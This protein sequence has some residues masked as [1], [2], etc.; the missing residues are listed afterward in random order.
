M[1][2]AIKE[3]VSKNK[4]RYK[5]DGFDLD[6][7]YINSNIIAMGYPAEKLEGIYRNHID[8][9]IKFL[10]SKHSGNYW[11][12]NLCSERSYDCGKF[13]DRVATYAFDDHNPPRMELIKPFCQDVDSWLSK[14]PR[15]VAAVHCKA[16]KGRTGVMICCYLLHRGMFLSAAQAL[17][18]YGQ[19]RTTDNRGVTIPSQRRY[20]EYYGRLVRE[21]SL[22]YKPR[23]VYLAAVILTPVPN[24]NTQN[25]CCSRLHSCHIGG[26]NNKI[27]RKGASFL[28]GEQISATNFVNPIF[29]KF[30]SYGVQLVINQL[31]E[32]K[33]REIFVWDNIEARKGD[34]WIQF[35][36]DEPVPLTGDI[37]VE[38]FNK[39]LMGKRDKMLRI[40]FNTF[41]VEPN[42]DGDLIVTRISLDGDWRSAPLVKRQVTSRV[43]CSDVGALATDAKEWNG[44]A[45]GAQVLAHRNSDPE[46]TPRA[47]HLASST[48]SCSSTTSSSSGASQHSHDGLHKLV[49]RLKSPFVHRANDGRS[50]Q[51]RAR[52]YT[53][54]L[55]L[56]P[57]PAGT[58][59]SFKPLQ[60]T[61]PIVE[62]ETWRED[63]SEA[64][65]VVP[66]HPEI[67]II[68][69]PITKE[70]MDK[71]CK[72]RHNKNF[73][74]EFRVTL[75]LA[76]THEAASK[77]LKSVSTTGT[78]MATGNKTRALR[79]CD[80]TNYCPKE[81]PA[82][83]QQTR[84]VSVI[85]DQRPAGATASNWPDSDEPVTGE[86]CSDTASRS[87]ARIAKKN[88]NSQIIEAFREFFYRG[89]ST[90]L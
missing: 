23:T 63:N 39:A 85:A 42:K 2:N 29:I 53:C 49:R 4:K 9:V 38:A 27:G 46:G 25:G 33:L 54:P 77:W 41:F 45:N 69:L 83:R 3:I 82:Q 31:D 40:W 73:S 90:H 61:S 65:K 75:Y 5:G 58:E 28:G 15:N 74:S 66:A 35:L 84:S 6:L 44:S 32:E 57:V 51:E 43:S 18:F 10:E 88:R 67:S 60:C 78:A 71:A 79:R 59:G 64:S 52:S 30:P 72:D 50:T 17:D 70:R 34:G 56:S 14:D 86:W 55:P 87:D 24:F 8:D 62:G 47:A 20:V 21:P 22:E 76:E 89:D 12:Y 1:A 37:R 68:T 36:V 48:S 26:Y 80:T 13:H 11:I 19:Q 81:Q 7:A 16:G